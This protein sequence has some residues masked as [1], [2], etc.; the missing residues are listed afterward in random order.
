VPSQQSDPLIDASGISRI[1]TL[2]TAACEEEGKVRRQGFG[3]GSEGVRAHLGHLLGH[4]SLHDLLAELDGHLLNAASLVGLIE[5]PVFVRSRAVDCTE[6]QVT[7][8]EA[9]KTRQRL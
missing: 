5:L 2:A 7:I 8:Q 6:T 4:A 9:I 1:H 3:V